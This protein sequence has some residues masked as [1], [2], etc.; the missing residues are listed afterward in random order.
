MH[1]REDPKP[2]RTTPAQ[3][4]RQVEAAR[5]ALL[6]RLAP[7]LRHEA[8][9][10]LQPIAMIG[11]VIERRLRAPVADM[12]A[13]QESV[14]RLTTLSRAAMQSCLDLIGWLAPEP[15]RRVPLQEAVSEAL[16][17]LRGPL[18]LRGFT[19]RDDVAGAATL[20][21]HA[22]L[23]YVL[24]ACLLWLTDC[25]GAPAEVTVTASRD[26]TSLR[27]TLALQ[28]TPGPQESAEAGPTDRPLCR[29]EVAA[30]A[31]AE[32]IGFDQ[33]GDTITLMLTA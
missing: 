19:L 4:C 11:G 20:V 30:L 13:M 16:S 21:P 27:V 2:A 5:H 15:G 33:Q 9:A 23:R 7:S 18:G 29:D 17:L 10:A 32:S 22:G 12:A 24:P 31:H 3:E 14:S 1:V 26:L 25:S 6:R 28:P 8:V